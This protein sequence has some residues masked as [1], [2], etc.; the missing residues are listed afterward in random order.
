MAKFPVALLLIAIITYMFPRFLI[1]VL[2]ESNPWTS[3]FYLYG[4]GL[5]FFS[6]GLWIILSSGACQ[7]GRGHDSFWFK[8]L[9]CGFIFFASL[10][11]LWVWLA[12]NLPVKGGL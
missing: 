9:V 4:H 7:L 10:H 11:G 12:I 6:V 5:I 3:Y 8:V 1:Q 2:G